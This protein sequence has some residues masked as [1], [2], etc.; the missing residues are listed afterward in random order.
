M[1][2]RV[3]IGAP[4]HVLYKYDRNYHRFLKKIKATG[5]EIYVK[6]AE[7]EKE[8]GEVDFSNFDMQL[9]NLKKYGVKWQPFLICG[10]FYSLPYWFLKSKDCYFLKC[11]EHNI[12]S[13]IQ[14]IWNPQFKKYVQR[15]LK[16]FYDHY[17]KEDKMIDSILL[18]ISGD[19]GEAIY[20]VVGNWEGLYHTHKGFWCNDDFAI[21]DFRNYLKE[22]F[23]KITNLN[24]RWGSSFSSF[25]EIKPFLKKDA[26]SRVAMIDMVYWYRLS[27]IR[28]AEF[29]AQEAR[30]LWKNKDIYLV[31]G[32]DG[33]AKEGQH[34]TEAARI[35]SKYN[36]GIRD[37]N[38]RDDFPYLNI[39]QL[40]TVVATNYYGS[41]CSFE[42][43]SGSDEKLIVARTFAF[44]ISNAKEF[45]EYSFHNNKKV[46]N[47]FKKYRE[48]MEIHFE[49][50]VEV[51]ILNPEPYVNWVHE[52]AISWEIKNLPWGLPLKLHALFYKLRY[53]FD[54]D[55]IDDS[56]IRNGILDNYRVL[57][58]PSFSIIEDDI[59][60]I[61]Y[62][63]VNKNKGKTIVF[64][65][66]VPEDVYG[67]KIN[68]G[69]ISHVGSL[70][71]LLKTLKQLNVNVKTR[72]DGIFEV[73]D[74]KGKTICFDEKKNKIYW[75][76]G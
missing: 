56:L 70:K 59:L 13:G 8:P 43:S 63:R 67:N 4:W 51:A 61:I 45:H 28:W 68:F 39:Y 25:E 9:E 34:Y 40:K 23:G 48:L 29:W 55:I 6:W 72:K 76:R 35:Y 22:R 58:I 11:L 2:K 47:N 19:Y 12:E 3:T 57:I 26:P 66:E 16:L 17:K 60:K 73:M 30:K 5:I 62:K 42:S 38:A 33:S 37:T 14:S 49:R 41:Y 36:I 20:P 44:I 7:I 46:V 64:G 15:F 71:G 75:K 31:M 32:G 21:I 69:E 10:P 52:H 54:F 53:Y 74:K 65:K 24:N 27:M 1:E 50:K 18:G